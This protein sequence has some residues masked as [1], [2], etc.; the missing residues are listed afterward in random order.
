MLFEAMGTEGEQPNVV[1][2]NV[3]INAYCKL[4]ILKEARKLRTKWKS[5]GWFLIHIL[6]RRSY[7]GEFISGNVDEA[8]RLFDEMCS[9]G[10]VQNVV[11]YTTM[12]SGL[13]KAGQSNES[14]ELY[15]EMKKKGYKIEDRVY[16]ALVQSLHSAETKS[17]LFE[18]VILLRRYG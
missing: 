18:V 4:R 6:T 2:Y 11:R 16:T 9:K 7:S 3:M 17:N 8:T 14:F 5:R 15:G 1:T 12:I 10:L 13:S